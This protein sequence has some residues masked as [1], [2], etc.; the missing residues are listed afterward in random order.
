M[1]RSLRD[2]GGGCCWCPSS[3]S[4]PTPA[5][6]CG[7]ASGRGAAGRGAAAVGRVRVASA[8]GPSGRGNRYLRCGHAGAPVN[9]SGHDPAR[10]RARHPR[11]R[12]P[13]MK[14]WSDSFRDGDAIRRSSRSPA[15]TRSCTSRWRRTA[16]P[17]RVV[18][19]ARGHALVRVLCTT[20]T[21]RA[22]PTTSTTPIARSGL[23]RPGRLL[24]LGAG[25]PAG[26]G[27]VG[28][29]RRVLDQVVPKGK[30]GP[31]T[32][33]GARTGSTTTPRG[34]RRTTTWRASTSAT[35]A[36]AARERRADPPLPVRVHA[37]DVER[38]PIEGRFTGGSARRDAG[39][40]LAA[41]P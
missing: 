22:C 23:A 33:H 40:V 39:H 24:P 15:S 19:R 32:R 16:T 36:R 2:V 28:R 21:R 7:R 1:N 20:S 29:G 13:D 11:R 27:G 12:D 25:R 41:R 30:P 34:S 8:G 14:L 26:D 17:P 38:L 31:E 9:T 6:A 18:G 37:L 5:A 3:R 35:T 4:R 10:R